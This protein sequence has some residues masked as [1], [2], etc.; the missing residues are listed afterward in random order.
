MAQNLSVGMGIDI[1]YNAV[2][3]AYA[4]TEAQEVTIVTESIP[5]VTGSADQSRFSFS[6]NGTT[7]YTL[8]GDDYF[9]GNDA[10][11]SSRHTNRREDR[12]WIETKEWAQL[13]AA[14]LTRSKHS[15]VSI[16]TGLPVAFFEDKEKLLSLINENHIVGKNGTDMQFKVLKS[17]VIPQPFGTIF[18]AVLDVHGNISDPALATSTIGVVDIGGKTTNI[19]TVQNLSERVRQTSSVNS[20]GWD[21]VRAVK[22][23]LDKE[24]P[25]NEMRDHEIASGIR[26]GNIKMFG[27][28]YNITAIVADAVYNL[29]LQIV[30]ECTQLWG[31]GSSI[32]KIFITGGGANL[33]GKSI[34]DSYR[35]ASVVAN[36]E[37]ANARGYAKLANRLLSKLD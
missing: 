2:K 20:G 8:S 6:G 22:I 33:I 31:Q 12:N 23:K 32:D 24:Y 26:N 35:H 15:N 10:I 36:P 17:A 21:V 9:V 13:F 29:S 3:I 14:A 28:T 11:N 37:F 34:A 30:S 1:G 27:K 5:S 19:L 18:D 16:V 7:V 4:D 25:D